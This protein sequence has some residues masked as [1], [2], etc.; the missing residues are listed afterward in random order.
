MWR[1]V[2]VVLLAGFLLLNI[3]AVLAGQPRESASTARLQVE[4]KHRFQGAALR[5]DDGNLV[6][7]AGDR[8]SVSRL[9]YLLSGFALVRADGTRVPLS[10]GPVYLNPAEGRTGFALTGVPIG[11]YRGL[12]FDVGLT[13]Q[14]NHADPT[15]YPAGHA[16]NPRVNSLH[17]GWQGGYV[18]LAVEGHYTRSDGR[19]GGYSYHIATDSNRASV[20]LQHDFRIDGPTA[21]TLDF[22]VAR[23]FTGFSPQTPGADSTHSAPG[24][25]LATKIK[26]NIEGAF[27]LA[28]AGSTATDSATVPE[29]PAHSAAT[30]LSGM[31]AY[32][33]VVPEGFP[34]P[35]LPADNPLTVE[36]VALGKRLFFER[37]LSG[38]GTQACASC[39]RPE[40]AFSDHGRAHSLGIDGLQGTRRTMPLFNLAW[41]GPYTWDGRRARL[42]DQALA[43]IANAREMH[44]SLS[45]VTRRLQAD[46][47]Y[48]A[49]FARAF[50]DRHVTAARMG[51]AM[52]QYLL[53]LISADS[54]F[55]RATRG[56]AQ[57]TDEEKR[58]LL[59]FITEYDPARGRIGADCFHCHGGNLFSDYRYANNGLDATFRDTGRALVT[60][61]DADVGKFKTPSLRNVA[62][63]GPYMHDGRFKTLEQVIDHYTS[64]VH[65]TATLD[66]NIAKHPDTG[67]ALSTADKHAL[68]AFLKTLTD[69]RFASKLGG[70]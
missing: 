61:R 24:D 17:W 38:D 70:K 64:G 66:P 13:P 6:T 68:V 5:M 42:R 69:A 25:A 63:T 65:R 45:R 1:T 43:P 41:S 19:P 16:L 60:Y 67:M 48:P 27:T 21:A 26:A 7:S 23:L 4:V 44:A 31:H 57:F 54:K 22:D 3:A 33:F 30:A 62:I 50:G 18:F 32:R 56:E 51:L 53:T 10:G 49:L 12:T 59:L 55:D 39:H 37:R 8:I 2:V 20:S 29:A 11:S 15:R 52:E 40:A 34:Q 36:G 28:E 47:D 14:V 46:R 35:E 58:G 9:A